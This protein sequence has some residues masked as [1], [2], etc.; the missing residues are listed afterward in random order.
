MKSK[1]YFFSDPAHGWLRVDRDTLTELGLTQNDFTEYS[2]IDI[3][4][5]Y[6]EEDHDALE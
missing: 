4:Y 3:H 6:L 2:Y 1:F 5:M